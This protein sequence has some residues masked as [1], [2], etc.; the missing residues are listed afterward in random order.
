MNGEKGED[1]RACAQRTEIVVGACVETPNQTHETTPPVIPIST[2]TILR[3]SN[4][5]NTNTN[6]ML[7]SFTKHGRKLKQ[8]LGGKKNKPDKTGVDNA[9]ERVDSSS[10]LLQPVP[11]IAAS[12]HGGEG[13]GTEAGERQAD[14]RDRSPQP[15]S[16]SV[17]RRDDDVDEKEVSEGR[18]RPGPDVGVVEDSGPSREAERIRPSLSSPPIPPTG[19]PESE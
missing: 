17:G 14:S 18:S 8:Q 6:D 13:S 2:S 7:K 3:L 11:H 5:E 16:V 1:P 12:G 4:T 15:G 10:S 19:E 9:E